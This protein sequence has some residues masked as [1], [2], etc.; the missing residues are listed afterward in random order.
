MTP[1]VA[2][3]DLTKRFGDHL[4]VDHVSLQVSPG[5]IYGFVG[6]NGAGKTTTIRMLL[7]M[8]EPDAGVATIFGHPIS[9]RDANVWSPVG[10]LVESPS[11]Y[12]EL[13]VRENLE[14]VRRLRG[15]ADRSAVGDV[16][17]QMGLDR[18]ADRRARTLSLGNAQRLGLAK[19]LLARPQLLIL[20]EPVN[21][22][23]PAGVVEIR[24]LLQRLAA[25]GAAV[26]MSSHLLS[27][28][29]RLANRIGVIH[30]GQM[31]EELDRAS[32]DDL[33]S[34][35][36]VDT[37]DNPAAI[38]LLGEHGVGATSVEDGRVR[39]DEAGAAKHPEVIAERIVSGGLAL[40]HLSV[41]EVDLEQHFMQL[42]GQSAPPPV[43]RHEAVV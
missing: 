11:A 28:V 1:A 31:I 33:G 22:L 24:G 27:E 36:T 38:S 6:L 37:S 26:L 16:I 18:Y 40:R 29:A 34:W 32:L 17:D 12:P 4:A 13:T 39:I 7:G 42:V 9:G 8:V 5:E 2:A 23:D 15:V 41:D 14:C 30:H 25:D 43:P 21:G 20:D 10:H 3:V 19:A 35:V